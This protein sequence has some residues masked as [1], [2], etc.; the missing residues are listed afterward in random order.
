ML[1]IIVP[2]KYTEQQKQVAAVK[3]TEFRRNPYTTGSAHLDDMIA[4]NKALILCDTHKRKFDAK[5]ARYRVHPAA[6]LKRVR[7]NCDVCK[8]FC[9][10]T[11]FLNEKDAWDEHVK[12]EKHR[13][14]LEYAH[15]VKE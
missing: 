11:L 2:G 15:F 13:R 12:V 3:R 5:R 9:L 14:G 7:G 4:L 8:Q 10:A 6:N 1:E